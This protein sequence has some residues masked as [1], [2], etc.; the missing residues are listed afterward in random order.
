MRGFLHVNAL[1]PIV[2]Q[3]FV[4]THK[5]IWKDRFVVMVRKG[6]GEDASK[7]FALFDTGNVYRHFVVIFHPAFTFSAKMEA[8]V[9]NKKDRI[10]HGKNLQS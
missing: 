1:L 5:T 6:T 2:D 8:H 7:R 4:G 9:T 10:F 3:D